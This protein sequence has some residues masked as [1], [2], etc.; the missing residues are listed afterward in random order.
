[1]NFLRSLPS[2]LFQILRAARTGLL[3]LLGPIDR[4]SRSFSWRRRLPPLWLRRHSAPFGVF[5]SASREF[6]ELLRPLGLLQPDDL[7]LDVGCG[8]GSIVP[9]LARQLG[10]GGRYIGV[11]RHSPSIRWCRSAFR[12]DQRLRF[13]CVA[14]GAPFPVEDG[15]AGL[16]LVRSV[17]T[18]VRERE[19]RR[20][21]Q[22]IRRVLA[23]GRK[24]VVTAL[25]FEKG[26]SEA[27]C[28]QDFPFAAE[29]GEERW[30]WKAQP[31]SGVA[32]ERGRF[33]RILAESGLRVDWFVAGFWPG[34][35]KPRGQ[36]LLFLS[37][38]AG[39]ARIG[40]PPILPAAKME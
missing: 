33:L 32:F 30:R 15:A 34:E 38:G 16:V 20:L 26:E 8:A 3:R 4:L 40:A 35:K 25:L 5:S 39:L 21:F 13:E 24:A 37:Y 12:A 19:A 7:V 2:P 22:E 27:L 9:A 14:A 18:H 1:M 28:E 11:D 23:P 36:D 17:F 29:D 6:D 31:E 10:D